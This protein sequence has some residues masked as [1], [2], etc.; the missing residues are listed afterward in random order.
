MWWIVIV[1]LICEAL[2]Y[3]YINLGYRKTIEK[4][5]NP[6]RFHLET[7]KTL[8]HMR[9]MCTIIK[10][11]STIEDFTRG[12]FCGA[13]V[14]SL[15][16]D[17]CL[18]FIAWAFVGEDYFV[19]KNSTKDKNKDE[20]LTMVEKCFDL[21]CEFFPKEMAQIKPGYNRHVRHV[22][23]CLDPVNFHHMPFIFYA[24][25]NFFNYAY[26]LIVM[27]L[28]GGWKASHVNIAP[29]HVNRSRSKDDFKLKYWYKNVERKDN[30]T[31]PQA[32]PVLFLHG[33]SYG[34]IIYAGMLSLWVDRPVLMIDLESIKIGTLSK[35]HPYAPAMAQALKTVLKNHGFEKADICGHSFGTLLAST[36]LNYTPE[37]IGTNLVLIDPVC[38]LLTLPDVA[39][40]FLYKPPVTMMEWMIQLGASREATIARTLYRD[41]IWF[42]YDMIL[43]KV[44]PHVNII[45][46]LGGR[47]EVLNPVCIHNYLTLFESEEGKKRKG[48]VK[49]M[50]LEGAAHGEVLFSGGVM[51]QIQEAIDEGHRLSREALST[52]GI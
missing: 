27:Q 39:Y 52:S 3:S 13:S 46:V 50:L 2:F 44:P 26:E 49:N 25:L 19:L 28:L 7:V 37:I 31:G 51:M 4:V 43:E 21:L 35:A 1:W 40:N 36:V 33:I 30:G 23:M 45:A 47:D 12:F 11:V 34:W 41:F 20:K 15:G 9:R 14:S 32:D 22:S 16:I 10:K 8:E 48:M 42:E 6:S 29:T 18:S 38:L 24:F 17:N 5:R